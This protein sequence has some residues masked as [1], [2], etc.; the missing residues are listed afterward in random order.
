MKILYSVSIYISYALS[1]FV[2]FDILWTNWI[3]LKYTDMKNK[4]VWEYVMRTGIVLL[5]CKYISICTRYLS[6][7]D[8]IDLYLYFYFLVV[9]AVAI[10]DLEL[11]ISFTGSFCLSTMGIAAPAIVQILV[12]WCNRGD[13]WQF[14]G[15]LF[16]NFIIILIAIFAFTV[17]VGTSVMKFFEK[18]G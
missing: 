15:L 17:G 1:N 14:T 4:V 18:Y 5:T 8:S 9:M 11:F 6:S 2:T 13:T 10:P 12:H 16:K 3:K 7:S